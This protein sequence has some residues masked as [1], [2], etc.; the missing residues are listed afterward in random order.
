[1]DFFPHR[2]PPTNVASATSA[3][4]TPSAIF[5][6]NTDATAINTAER[7]LNIVGSAGTSG[8]SFNAVGAQGARGPSG[9]RGSRGKN[10]YLL[11]VT[12]SPT[13]PGT[14]CYRY[15]LLNTGPNVQQCCNTEGG[16][17]YYTTESF[18]L[19][20]VGTSFYTDEGCSIKVSTALSVHAG[21]GDV[22]TI[23]SSGDVT[24]IEQCLSYCTQGSQQGGGGYFESPPVQ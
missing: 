13:Y 12:R 2:A 16:G 3:S 14:F 22:I 15:T 24:S 6:A 23:N 1:M 5:L 20:E 17:Q 10:I 21:L 7:A 18:G 8:V 4:N 19:W 9:A 11:D